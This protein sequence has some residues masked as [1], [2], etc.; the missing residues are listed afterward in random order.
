MNYISKFLEKYYR[1]EYLILDIKQNLKSFDFYIKKYN[2]QGVEK[3]KLFL[4]IDCN[5]KIDLSKP[6][7]ISFVKDSKQNIEILKDFLLGQE[8]VIA[9]EFCIGDYEIILKLL[10]ID[11][12]DRIV[13]FD[14][15]LSFMEKSFHKT[16]YKNIKEKISIL[17]A[18]YIELGKQANNILGIE[19]IESKYK[20]VYEEIQFLTNKIL[21]RNKIFIKDNS[22]LAKLIA[23]KQIPYLSDIY[24]IYY[25]ILEVCGLE[26]D[27]KSFQEEFEMIINNLYPQLNPNGEIII[28]D[29][30]ICLKNKDINNLSLSDKSL[31]L[32]SIR[33]SLIV[34][35][36]KYNII[37]PLYFDE[38]YSCIFHSEEDNVFAIFKKL[39]NQNTIFAE[40]D[41]KDFL[42][43]KGI[44]ENTKIY[45]S[46]N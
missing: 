31:V 1:Q 26:C 40:S 42:K 43:A 39:F 12:G 5:K 38:V 10:N 46:K 11:L 41:K 2:K 28:I 25:D 36:S 33:F 15:I 35:M 3:E 21:K 16:I 45:K 4:S 22:S 20:F 23:F 8:I 32:L 17:N 6:N 44:M 37:L 13:M 18:R 14:E 27:K 9:D 19:E 7:T 30:R 34:M 29:D 24:G